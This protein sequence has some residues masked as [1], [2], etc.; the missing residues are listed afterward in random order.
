MTPTVNPHELLTQAADILRERAETHGDFE[1]NFQLIADMFSLRVGR[2]FH[3][4][5]VCI[6][7]ECVKDARMFANPANADNYLDGINYRAFAALFAE[8]Y[9]MKRNTATEVAYRRKAD[10]QK[11]EM[12][13][14]TVKRGRKPNAEKFDL[15]TA[16][17]SPEEFIS[18]QKT[19]VD[20]DALAGEIIRG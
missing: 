18:T 17:R 10:L 14:V 1:N 3:P 5:E 9:A 7:L 11:A 8:D 6:L 20:L 15:R 13:P 4:F 12:A 19:S 16:T 2:E